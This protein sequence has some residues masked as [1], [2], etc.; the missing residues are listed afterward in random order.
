GVR[1]GT[2]SEQQL[3]DVPVAGDSRTRKRFRP[4]PVAGLDGRAMFQQTLG[5]VEAAFVG[6]VEQFEVDFGGARP[7]LDLL[8]ALLEAAAHSLAVDRIRRDR[9]DEK[10][11][12]SCGNTERNAGHDGLL[13]ML[14]GAAGGNS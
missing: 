10:K 5:Q 9:R 4:E 3:G 7:A 2:V 11:G 8:E 1:R 12:G 6:S 14:V 13:L